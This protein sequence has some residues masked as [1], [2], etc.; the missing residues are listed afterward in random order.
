ME[1]LKENFVHLHVHSEYS[2]LDGLG[3]I[4]DLVAA[5]K[6]LGMPALA[7]TDHGVMYGVSEFSDECRKQGIKPIIGC[8]IYVTDEDHTLHS[9]DSGTFHGVLLCKNETGYKNLMEIV[10]E[11]FTGGFYRK[12]RVDHKVLAAHSEGLIFLSACLSGEIPRAVLAG[13][14]ERA[15]ELIRT[16]KK[17]FGGDF[18]LEIQDHRIPEEARVRE[19]LAE[20]SVKY[21]VPLVAT[22]DVHY[23][24][25]EDWET[26]D[27]LICIQTGAKVADRE[28]MRYEPEQ[29]Y[30]KSPEEMRKE[31]VA[32]EGACDATLEIADKCDFFIGDSETNHMPVFPVPEKYR[33]AGEYLKALV[34]AG[35]RKRY[36][37]PVPKDVV[38]RIGLELKTIHD[39]DFD[40][41][42]LVVWDFIHYA[43][44]NGIPV[45]PGRG[46]AAGSVV[47][48]CLGIT[49]LDPLPYGLH[50]ERFLNPERYTM[51]DI[52]TDI[53]QE[54]RQDVIDYV[55]GKYGRDH[56]AQIVTY[57]TMLGRSAIRD[58]GRV[59]GVS[60]EKV[61]S[62]AKMI[63]QTPGKTVPISECLKKD[64]DLS[65]LYRKDSEAAR[66]LD[67]ASAL[68]GIKRHASTHA[69]GIVVTDRPVDEYVPLC[70]NGDVLATQFSMN[71]LEDKGLIKLDILGLRVLTMIQGCCR[72]IEENTGKRINPD[73]IDLSDPNIYRTISSGD[74]GGVFQLEAAG[75]SAF[76][77]QLEPVCF[78]DVIAGIALYRPGPM[79]SIPKYLDCRAHPEHK[80]YTHPALKPILEVTDSC[81]IYQEQV[82]QIFRD[83]AGFSMG[84]SDI[85]R[86]A[87]SKKKHDVMERE[88]HVFVYGETAEDGTV[89]VDGCLRRGIPKEAALAVWKDM[90]SFASYAFNKSHSACY[91]FIACQTAWLK[92]YYPAEFYAALLTSFIGDDSRLA[93][94]I[95]EAKAHGIEVLPPDINRSGVRFS[96]NRGRILYGLSGVKGLG[97]SLAER[98]VLAREKGFESLQDVCDRVEKLNSKALDGLV[99]AGAFDCIDTDRKLLISMIPSALKEGRKNQKRGATTSSQESFFDLVLPKKPALPRDEVSPSAVEIM[100]MEKESLGLYLSGHPLEDYA[101]ELRRR[102]CFDFSHLESYESLS[103]VAPDKSAVRFGC[104]LRDVRQHT[105]K[106]GDPMAFAKAEDPYGELELVI[107]PRVFQRS[108]KLIEDGSLVYVLGEI[109]YDETMRRVSVIARRIEPLE[110]IKRVH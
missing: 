103:A 38:A 110:R 4:Q 43:K 34:S 94:Y 74:N 51:P 108:K 20:L 79:D 30:L 66:I 64:K 81:L 80:S 22:N 63:P 99:R 84:R 98:I 90:E 70:R 91:A 59:F 3:K 56:V 21:S 69:A 32:F 105:T 72:M 28:R 44:Q 95:Q 67:T 68:E 52:D 1:N 41:Y 77:Q 50:F 10:S 27:A 73:R 60:Y 12:P 11:G 47:S 87:M 104:L 7:L 106:K 61:D 96:A 16:Y 18:Y 71:E 5:A 82:M 92:H 6:E 65:D 76:M 31:F 36:G 26:H 8:E 25:K 97:T 45:G 107:F 2:L 57:G 23:V 86:R 93:R 24:R 19:A 39:M 40:N 42:F 83:L 9:K 55:A 54:G 88:G 58:A 102:H 35:A 85:V 15:E 13:N 48:Y 75:M 14:I 17:I 89:I 62:I 100:A 46:S 53:A 33:D 101:G 29:F 78:E 109:Q 37:S 49:E